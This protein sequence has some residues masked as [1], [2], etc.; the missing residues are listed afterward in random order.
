MAEARAADRIVASAEDR[1][2]R[3]LSRADA[4]PDADLAGAYP[5]RRVA[6]VLTHL[7]AWHLLLEGWL[8]DEAAGR[9]VH[10]PAEGFTWAAL[11]ALNDS[12]YEAHRHLDYE[13]AREALVASH[14]R[15]IALVRDADPATLDSP[16]A[17]AWLG[18]E[19]LGGVAHECLGAHYAWAE[20]VL[21]R[22]GLPA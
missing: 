15:A 20:G 13:A 11:D 5:G 4:H 6:D 12:L 14:R 16:G 18:D 21:D 7:H 10:F 22:A 9:P 17:L 3:L 19:T 1:L 2:A 8:A